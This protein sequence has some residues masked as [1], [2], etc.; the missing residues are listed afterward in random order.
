MNAL[1]SESLFGSE[2]ND[3][4]RPLLCDQSNR[5]SRRLSKYRNHQSDCQVKNDQ[6][7]H[8]L[9]QQETRHIE[10]LQ[11]QKESE[12]KSK[13]VQKRP[14]KKSSCNVS[15]TSFEIFCALITRTFTFRTCNQ[16]RSRSQSNLRMTLRT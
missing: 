9:C 5:F 3:E 13:R 8:E 1:P 7:F 15:L 10:K 11:K 6:S 2:E 12:G 4:K 16:H 14:S